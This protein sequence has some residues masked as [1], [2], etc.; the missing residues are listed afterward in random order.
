MNTR[1]IELR[2][3]S[4]EQLLYYYTEYIECRAACGL[5]CAF[6]HD[7]LYKI[8]IEDIEDEILNRMTYGPNN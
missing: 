5:Q 8:N 4:N 2:S 7:I 6:D 3:M 1:L